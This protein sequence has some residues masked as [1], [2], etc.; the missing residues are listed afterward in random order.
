MN[1]AKRGMNCNRVLAAKLALSAV[2]SRFL[3]FHRRGRRFSEKLAH[4]ELAESYAAMN[5]RPGRRSNQIT[6]ERLSAF[7]SNPLMNAAR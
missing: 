5:R 6:I 4:H 7:Q 2:H 1:C 3:S